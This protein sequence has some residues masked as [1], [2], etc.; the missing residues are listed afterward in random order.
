MNMGPNSPTHA[1]MASGNMMAMP[2]I[3]IAGMKSR[4][5][6]V[7][8]VMKSV[9]KEGTHYGIIPGTPKPSLWKPGAEIL[10]Q[11]FGLVAETTTRVVADDPESEW[12]WSVTRKNRNTH[13]DY[14]DEG[15]CIGYFEVES[16]C[17]LYSGGMV[18]GRASARCNNRENKYRGLVLWDVRNT[19][20]QMAAKRAHVASV[21]TTTGCSDIFTQDVEDLSPE[22]LAAGIKGGGAPPP[23]AQSHLSPKQQEVCRTKGAAMKVPAEVIT[24]AIAT[25]SK[26]EVRAFMDAVFANKAEVFE[27][28]AATLRAKKDA[29]AASATT[30]PANAEPKTE[31]AQA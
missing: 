10:C 30:E 12:S 17:T 18:V 8:D 3:S 28:F 2:M 25:V 6:A 13:E 15:T 14:Q 27:P 23:P 5:K 21:R 24:F 9:M 11:L 26:G 29:A 1:G 31:G 20:D 7:Q 4:V 19:I 16:T 22:A